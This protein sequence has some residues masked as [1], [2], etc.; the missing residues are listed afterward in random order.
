MR[1]LVIFDQVPAALKAHKNNT[2]KITLSAGFFY[3]A[4]LASFGNPLVLT[5]TAVSSSYQATYSL[6]ALGSF[7]GL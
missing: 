4:Y 1:R 2:F 5:T 6:L 7:F 3:M